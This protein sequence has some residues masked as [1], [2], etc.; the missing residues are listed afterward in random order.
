MEWKF[1]RPAKSVPVGEGQVVTW[2]TPPDGELDRFEF[3][4]E[5]S[6]AIYD[7]LAAALATFEDGAADY[8]NAVAQ[9]D[10]LLDQSN[11]ATTN[12]LDACNMIATWVEPVEAMKKVFDG[13][14]NDLLEFCRAWISE[15][16]DERKP[17]PAAD[18][19]AGE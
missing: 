16:R 7:I 14:A 5:R 3:A 12:L 2:K 19:G 9:I 10:R 6:K 17:S 1:D 8:S 18:P 4:L 13:K 15:Q 11:I